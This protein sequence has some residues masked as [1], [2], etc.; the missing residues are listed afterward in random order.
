[1]TILNKD[2]I[3]GALDLPQETV[4]V[5]EWGGS[6]IVRA[7]TGKE[8]DLFESTFSNESAKTHADKM[9]NVRARLVVQCVVDEAGERL[10]KDSDLEALGGKSAKALDR[11]FEVAQRLSGLGKDIEEDAGNSET[12]QNESS[13]SA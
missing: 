11:V 3:L 12:G 9:A 2:A 10:F 13:T 1:M 8:R 6:V 4:E 5:P 7:L